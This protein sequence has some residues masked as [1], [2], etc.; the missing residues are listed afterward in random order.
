MLLITIRS[1][2]RRT[3]GVKFGRGG[4]GV[5]ADDFVG[6]GVVF[7][8]LEVSARLQQFHQVAEK[9]HWIAGLYNAHKEADVDDVVAILEVLRDLGEDVHL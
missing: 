5:R 6:R 2:D 4:A 7:L 9:G 8:P 1:P 3:E